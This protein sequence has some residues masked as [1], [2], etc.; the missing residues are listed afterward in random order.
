M[1]VGLLSF[2][3]ASVGMFNAAHPSVL[4]HEGTGFRFTWWQLIGWNVGEQSAPEKHLLG[5]LPARSY[6]LEVKAI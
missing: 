2:L 6:T 3:V 5:I 1:P 4:V